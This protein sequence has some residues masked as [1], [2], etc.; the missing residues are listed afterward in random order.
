MPRVRPSKV[1]ITAFSFFVKIHQASLLVLRQQSPESLHLCPGHKLVREFYPENDIHCHAITVDTGI[2]SVAFIG[3]DRKKRKT[4]SPL[5][6]EEVWFV[7]RTTAPKNGKIL[8]QD[9]RA[10]LLPERRRVNL[11]G[12][13]VPSV[14]MAKEVDRELNGLVHN[15]P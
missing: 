9:Q 10:P 7:Q 12:C 1:K 11:H 4:H 6:L 5:V 15:K 14:W 2:Y 8:H 3:H 13:S